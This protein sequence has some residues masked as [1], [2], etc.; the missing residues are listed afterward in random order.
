MQ[1]TAGLLVVGLATAA[2]AQPQVPPG[3]TIRKIAPLLDGASAKLAAVDDPDFGTGVLSLTQTGAV[4]TVR[5]VEAGGGI[6]TVAAFA[7]PS[8][9]FAYTV[10]HDATPIFGG[11]LH[12][13]FIRPPPNRQTRYFTIDPSG[14]A[15]YRLA[16]NND[17]TAT[18]AFSLGDG[19]PVGSVLLDDASPTALGYVDTNYDFHLVSNNSVPPGR[20]DLD[21][22]D[23]QWDATGHFGGGLLLAD[24]DC[25]SDDR[26]GIYRLYNIAAGGSYE[27]IGDLQTC[28]TRRLRGLA[29]SDSPVFG[30]DV[31]VTDGLADAIWRVDNTGQYHSFATD[32]V[33]PA[34]LEISP[35]GLSMYVHDA[36]GVWLIRAEG[37]EPGPV[38][39]S[40]E[41][42]AADSTYL[43]GGP[44]QVIRLIFSEPV[45]FTGTD[46]AIINGDGQ[47]VGFD[48][49]GS[50][51]QFMLIG[52][53]DPLFGD[54]YTLTIADTVTAIATGT[55]LDGDNDGF[56]GG[57]AVLEFTHRC[58]GDFNGDETVNTLDVLAFL[59]A[60][61]AGCP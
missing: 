59:N 30:L 12:A 36:T 56:A 7:V 14:Q 9:F 53:A 45:S 6:R 35:D 10:L 19:E 42:A 27:L 40:Q 54:T 16:I 3:F 2:V 24:S 5:L 43:G 58:P 4:A 20:S 28:A 39:I 51:S 25:N 60:W 55:S 50:G 33:D 38:I 8:G 34:A 17:I 44:V 32:F 13:S 31:Y 61:T 52:L 18:I 29:I 47:P 48:V 15:T 37:D 1:R 46:I 57:D 21:I 41:P 49:S 26:S 22:I 11:E 23:S